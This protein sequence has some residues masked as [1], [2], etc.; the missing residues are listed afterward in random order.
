MGRDA[1]KFVRSVNN[2]TCVEYA[3]EAVNVYIN[4]KLESGLVSNRVRLNAKFSLAYP[5]LER[6]IDVVHESFNDFTKLPEPWYKLTQF[7]A[8]TVK[9]INHARPQ[10]VRKMI[11]HIVHDNVIRNWTVNENI[12]DLTIWSTTIGNR[13]VKNKEHFAEALEQYITHEHIA[14]VIMIKEQLAKNREAYIHVGGGSSGI[15]SVGI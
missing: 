6:Y 3:R 9:D 7:E 12:E 10:H 11:K 5:R 1:D 14:K 2:A 13:L 8:E 15:G 4:K